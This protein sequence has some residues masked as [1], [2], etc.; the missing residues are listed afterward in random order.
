M[1]YYNIATLLKLIYLF[2]AMEHDG[3]GAISDTIN[4]GVQQ[5]ESGGRAAG[6][7]RKGGC[8]PQRAPIADPCKNIQNVQDDALNMRSSPNVQ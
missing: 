8:D 3:M 1:H 5:D 6:W 7:S 2:M 4:T